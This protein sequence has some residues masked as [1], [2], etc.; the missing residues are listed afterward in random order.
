M[1]V[2]YSRLGGCLGVTTKLGPLASKVPLSLGKRFARYVNDPLTHGVFQCIL[3]LALPAW[4]RRANYLG[5]TSYLGRSAACLG[6]SACTVCG[7]PWLGTSAACLGKVC[8]NCLRRRATCIGGTDTSCLG[9]S[10]NC[11]GRTSCLGRNVTSLALSACIA[12]SHAWVGTSAAFLGKVSPNCLGG[13]ATCLGDLI[14]AAWIEVL[15][16]LGELVLA[17]PSH[18]G[19]LP[20]CVDFSFCCIIKQLVDPLG[21]NIGC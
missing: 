16:A 14:L 2:M 6:F 11:L 12:C 5:R 8:L 21:Q 9:R 10:A 3:G 15:S 18:I 4:G 1:V 17:V 19:Q 7:H 13:R 20:F